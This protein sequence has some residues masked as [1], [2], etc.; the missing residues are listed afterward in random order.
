LYSFAAFYRI[1]IDIAHCMLLQRLAFLNKYG[2]H[3][4]SWII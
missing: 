3:L 2:G 1:S 4:S